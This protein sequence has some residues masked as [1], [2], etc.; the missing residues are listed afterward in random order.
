MAQ[1]KTNHLLTISGFS[2]LILFFFSCTPSAQENKFL[3]DNYTKKEYRIEMRDGVKLLTAVYFPKDN[4][5]K[6][7]III[8]RTPY[9]VGPYGED[10]FAVYRRYTWQH[11]IE[12]KYII[13]FQDVRGRFMSEGDFVNMTPY[14]PEKKSNKDI[15]ETTDT[16]D[17]VDWLVKNIPNN[18]GN[19]GLWGISYP[20][21]YAAM[22]GIDAHPAVKAISPQA[23]IADWFGNDDWHHNGA[24]AVGSGFPFMHVFGVKRKGLVQTWPEEFDFG[25]GDGYGFYLNLGPLPNINKKYFHHEIPFWDDLMKHGT[26]DDFWKARNSLPH[27]NNIKPAVLVV[28]GWFDAENLYGALHT[29]SSI[30]EKNPEN[31][32]YLVMGPW[33]HGGWVRTD[34]SSLGDVGFGSKTGEYYVK[35]IELPFFNYYLKGKGELN[36]PEA[37]AFE[38]GSNTWQKYD[39]WPPA[40]ATNVSLYLNKNNSLSLEAPQS[41]GGFDEYVSDPAKPVPYTSKITIDYPRPYMVEDQRFTVSRPDVLVY[42]T[43]ILD[44]DITFAGTVTADLFVSTTGT[45][46]D[47]VVKLIDVF[48]ADSSITDSVVY[49]EYQ[50]MVRGNILRGKFRESL[51]TP[52]PFKPGEVTNIKFDLLDI[53]HTFKKGHRIMVQIQSSWFPLFDRNPQKF[54]DIYNA[55]E[56]D[57]QKA[58]Q[59]V[60]FSKQYPSRIILQEIN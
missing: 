5:E 17:T 53:N 28:G 33:I 32:N 40:N 6:Y 42:K 59:R 35:N 51:E 41:T 7:P 36:L 27:F 45:D 37:Y 47:W 20:G 57:F 38:T 26:Y 16:Y 19:V 22:A 52:K 14:I 58:T 46:A 49:S 23:P 50:M 43:E 44:K 24:F 48:P 18:N 21:F 25:T 29:Y 11:F 4:S 55:K 39:S 60:Y 13:V 30:E 34:G 15:D 31:K 3:E 56:E 10:K 2:F 54:V 12:E 1:N 8:W 9:G